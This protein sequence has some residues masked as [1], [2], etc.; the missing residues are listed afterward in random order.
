METLQATKKALTTVEKLEKFVNQRSGIEAGNYFS[1]WRD[2]DGIRA[3]RQ[4]RAEITRDRQDF[5]SLLNLAFRRLNE[6]K[7]NE[8]LTTYLKTTNGRLNLNEAGHLQY[9]TGQYFPTEYRP[10]A[11]RV[12]A[13]II[14]NDYANEEMPNE[15]NPVYKDGHEMRK[16]IAKHVSR[17]VMKNYFN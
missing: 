1:D 4:E 13:Q 9:C 5:Y 12:L 7:L 8:K 3:Y 6:D 2:A 14:W 17:R 11:S 15:P 10:A 16:A